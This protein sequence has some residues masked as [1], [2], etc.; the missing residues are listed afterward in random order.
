MEFRERHPLP[1]LLPAAH[2]FHRLVLIGQD[3]SWVGLDSIYNWMGGFAFFHCTIYHTGMLFKK[4]LL[5]FE[6]WRWD[7]QGWVWRSFFSGLTWS[8][9]I[10]VPF[11][12]ELLPLLD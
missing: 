9:I 4:A 1:F 6:H 2:P 7:G 3:P 5:G 11:S 8:R 10:I 12:L